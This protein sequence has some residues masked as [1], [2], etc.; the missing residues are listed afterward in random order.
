[1]KRNKPLQQ[2]YELYTPE[3]FKVWDT[4]F[5]RQMQYL[6]QYGSGLYLDSVKRIGFNALEIP[7]I[8]KTSE[9]LYC[10]TGWQVTV[11]PELVP[12][13]SFFTFLSQKVFPVTCW[14][15][16]MA[17]LDYLEEPDMFHDVFG[18]LPLLMDDAYAGF[19]E[20]IG[21]LA[22]KWIDT[23]E[24][25]SLLGRIYWFTIEFGLLKEKGT[26]K[27]FGAG[28]VS[29]L[30]ETINSI[31]NSIAKNEF[32]LNTMIATDYRTDILQDRYFVMEST[33]QLYKSLPAIEG[34]LYN[35]IEWVSL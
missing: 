11:A 32:D 33:E 31:S 28:I 17:E 4:L 16:T 12:Q 35:V 2:V 14:L 7:D 6:H 30:G 25:I 27:I 13:K 20:G 23:P 18:H 5:N 21:K 3:D 24:A 26:P 8:K 9:R 19:M 10:A 29:S 15:R 22:I 1:M 34:A